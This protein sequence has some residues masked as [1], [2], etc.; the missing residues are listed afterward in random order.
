[1]SK[2]NGIIFKRR[3]FLYQLTVK[4]RQILS[5]FQ[6]LRAS[7]TIVLKKKPKKTQIGNLTSKVSK[8]VQNSNLIL[9]RINIL[10]IQISFGY[11]C[12]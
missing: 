8:N 6:K 5:K 1:M 2:L 11:F 10:L 9:G 12:F 4:Q 7:L 3:K